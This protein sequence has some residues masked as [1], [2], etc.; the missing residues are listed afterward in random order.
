MSRRL[1]L[2]LRLFTFATVFV[3]ASYTRG[4]ALPNGGLPCDPLKLDSLVGTVS[5]SLGSDSVVRKAMPCL[6]SLWR[7]RSSGG[8]Q[9]YIS[10][11]FLSVMQENP[12]VFF[13]DHER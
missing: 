13:F 11:A 8:E 9:F 3:T 4:S 5:L 1:G 2:L 10:N 6:L 12:S 7:R